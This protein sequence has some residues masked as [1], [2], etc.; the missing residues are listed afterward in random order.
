MLKRKIDFG[1]DL[2]MF[3]QQKDFKQLNSV[4]LG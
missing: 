1:N 4:E 3:R 2:M